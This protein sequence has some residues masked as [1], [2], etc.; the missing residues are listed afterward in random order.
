VSRATLAIFCASVSLTA[1]GDDESATQHPFAGGSSGIG[2]S[3]G[4]GGGGALGGSGGSSGGSGAGGALVCKPQNPY[5]AG[6]IGQDIATDDVRSSVVAW[7]PVSERYVVLHGQVVGGNF[8]TDMLTVA[9]DAQ[10]VSASAAVEITDPALPTV[11]SLERE[12]AIGGGK[13]LALLED[14]RQG[15]ATREVMGQFL[16]IDANGAPSTDG[17]SFSVTTRPNGHE[18]TP[19]VDWDSAANTFFVSWSDDREEASVPDGRLVFGRTVSATGA[20][21]PEVKLGGTSRWQTGAAVAGSGGNGRFL[22]AFG[23]YDSVNGGIDSGYRARVVDENG[24]A[25]SEII[26][27]ARFGDKTIDPVS[28]AWQPCAKEWLIAWRVDQT[29]YGSFVQLDGSGSKD[30]FLIGVH[31]EGA[32]APR[33]RWLPATGGFGLTFHAWTTENAFFQLLGAGGELEGTPVSINVEK[34][35]LGTFWHPLAARPDRAELLI[36]PVLDFER[37]TASVFSSN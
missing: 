11:D 31:P 1:C 22:V 33:L 12:I 36:T 15:D 25:V 24:Q 2:G 21:G 32:G 23:D 34:P 7:D 3:A 37:V 29:V 18:Y 9:V 5:L 14:T 28:I 26:E 30:H 19:S 17:P 8:R 6:V 13:I 35:P 10:T 27:I 16:H 20:L 4:F